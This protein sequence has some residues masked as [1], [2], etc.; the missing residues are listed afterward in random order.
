MGKL[1]PYFTGPFTIIEII[2]PNV[3]RINRLNR[4]LNKEDDTV[5]VNKLKYYTENILFLAHP[6]LIQTPR[7]TPDMVCVYLL[8]VQMKDVDIGVVT[9]DLGHHADP[10]ARCHNQTARQG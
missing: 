2:S 10:D 7:I 8:V 1:A 5:H 9:I 6:Q 3:V 4:P